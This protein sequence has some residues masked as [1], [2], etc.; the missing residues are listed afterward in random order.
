VC[1]STA[2]NRL[3]ASNEDE[4]TLALSFAFIVSDLYQHTVLN[5]AFQFFPWSIRGA[6][7]R[8]F[9]QRETHKMRKMATDGNRR[10]HKKNRRPVGTSG[11]NRT[12]EKRENMT[13]GPYPVRKHRNGMAPKMDRTK[14]GGKESG[15]TTRESHTN[16]KTAQ[17]KGTREK[18]KEERGRKGARERAGHCFV[19]T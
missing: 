2:L 16:N 19:F 15:A 18:N 8:S 7:R 17:D 11:D 12:Q 9:R 1:C 5:N 6:Q 13:H 3:S 4:P 10:G 14:R